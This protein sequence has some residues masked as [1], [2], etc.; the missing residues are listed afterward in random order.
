MYTQIHSTRG[1]DS[2]P[3]EVSGAIYDRQIPPGGG[4]F[5]QMRFKQLI[6][7]PETGRPSGIIGRWL[8][9]YDVEALDADSIGVESMDVESK[10]L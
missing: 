7:T 4:P 3:H 5:V 10:R 1:V 2:S 6:A 9:V 8:R